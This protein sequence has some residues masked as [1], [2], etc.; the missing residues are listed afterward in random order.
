MPDEHADIEIIE[1]PELMDPSEYLADIPASLVSGVLG[2]MAFVVSCVVGLLAGNPGYV[3]LLRAMLAML[4]CA[5]VGRLIGVVGEMCVREFVA[6]YKSE[7]PTPQKPRQLRE[8]EAT[9]RAH[10]EVMQSMKKSG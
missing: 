6:I 1:E 7:R 10:E 9:K 8:L 5:F 3:I 2:M 4:I